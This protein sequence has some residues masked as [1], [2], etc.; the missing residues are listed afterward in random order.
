MQCSC[1]RSSLPC[2]GWQGWQ[3]FPGHLRDERLTAYLFIILKVM[4][5]ISQSAECMW[6]LAF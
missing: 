5:N 6:R 1:T 4:M 2:G 3:G